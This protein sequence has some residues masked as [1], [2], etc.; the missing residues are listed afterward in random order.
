M[1]T[2]GIVLDFGKHAGTLLTRVPV[3]YLR[4]MA[5]ETDKKDM[6]LA[7]LKRRGTILPELELSGHSINRFSLRFL[8]VWKTNKQDDEGLHSFMLR[9]ASEALKQEC[10]GEIYTYMGIKFVFEQ[11]MEYPILK[12]VL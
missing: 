11:N 12:T 7:E 10:I 3:S 8:D 5:N 9:I 2:H 4:W 1:N 6:A